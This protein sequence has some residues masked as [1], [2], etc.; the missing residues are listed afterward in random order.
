MEAL[1]ETAVE[2]RRR[3]L[4]IGRWVVGERRVGKSSRRC[5]LWWVEL[6]VNGG[7]GLG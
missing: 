2:R 3:R 4:G 5:P 6:Q 1:W 7:S